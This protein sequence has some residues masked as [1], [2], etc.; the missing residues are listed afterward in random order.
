VHGNTF[1]SQEFDADRASCI[2]EWL[3]H[4]SRTSTFVLC[5]EQAIYNFD[6][7]TR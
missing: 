3:P 1:K 7:F 2:E 4:S 6:V 5:P